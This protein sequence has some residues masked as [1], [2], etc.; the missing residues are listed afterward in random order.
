MWNMKKETHLKQECSKEI[1]AGIDM[2]EMDKWQCPR[3]VDL[4]KI[5]MD[6]EHGTGTTGKQVEFV[7]G[8]NLKKDQLRILQ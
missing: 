8:K 2:L 6:R 3:C 4:E 7:T 1:R 5:R